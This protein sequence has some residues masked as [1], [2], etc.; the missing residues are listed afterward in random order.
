MERHVKPDDHQPSP[1]ATLQDEESDN[2]DEAGAETSAEAAA[3]VEDMAAD[4]QS[5]GAQLVRHDLHVP[6]VCFPRP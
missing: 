3:L 1:C 4:S 5:S 2:G 6:R